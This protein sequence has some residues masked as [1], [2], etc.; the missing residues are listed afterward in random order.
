M[1]FLLSH[2]SFVNH[3]HDL[4]QLA[5]FSPDRFLSSQ[6]FAILD[7]G[8]SSLMQAIL[9]GDS[10]HGV[11][12]KILDLPSLS[13]VQLGR[14]CSLTA[15]GFATAPDL[16]K[17]S[18]GY[19]FHMFYYLS[20]PAVISLFEGLCSS[21]DR[22]ICEWLLD[23]SFPDILLRELQV[24]PIPTNLNEAN[25]IAGLF[26]IFRAC[27]SSQ[28]R[29]SVCTPAFVEA[30]CQNLD[31]FPPFVEDLRWHCLSISYCGLTS[32]LMCGLFHS[33]ISIVSGPRS[34]TLSGVSALELMTRML[35]IDSLLRPF[36]ASEEVLE[37]PLR[38]LLTDSNHSILMAAAREFVMATIMHIETRAAALTFV[39]PDLLAAAQKVTDPDRIA[40]IHEVL[41]AAVN[42]GKTDLNAAVVM[43][44]VPGFTE[45]VAGPLAARN[46]MLNKSYGG[47]I[48][49]PTCKDVK[50]LINSP[51]G[52][53]MS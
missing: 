14:L 39:L 49:G 29:N 10:L 20:E 18:C 8:N 22:E 24:I 9:L 21:D 52:R 11:A 19:V 7:A 33:A 4:L 42:I 38:I 40:S 35:K 3:T 32:E 13:S 1:V 26:Q 46:A 28:L 17:E 44:G 34:V 25:R 36:M 30:L 16:A 12:F 45:F 50:A 48:P 5:F 37:I 47:P 2:S 53:Y 41:Q 27:A 6:A 15:A 51:L 43:R 31:L 23:V